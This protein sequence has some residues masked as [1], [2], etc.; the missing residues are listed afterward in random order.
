LRSRRRKPAT[1]SHTTELLRESL[2]SI[3][4][5]TRVLYTACVLFGGSSTSCRLPSGPNYIEL[6][7]SGLLSLLYKCK[8]IC[9]D[10]TKNQHT[11]KTHVIE[12]T[13]PSLS[14]DRRCRWCRSRSGR[15]ATSSFATPSSAPKFDFEHHH[16]HSKLASHHDLPT[17]VT[18]YP[19]PAMQT[20]SISVSENTAT[21]LKPF[22][23]T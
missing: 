2:S 19:P 20:T 16:P 15:K 8:V 7:S 11:H 13:L 5:R 1:S 21:R 23:E 18:G 17:A 3:N 10:L 22:A 9:N 12:P 6:V 4:I 14:S